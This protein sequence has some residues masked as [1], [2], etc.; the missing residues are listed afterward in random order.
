MTSWTP[1]A[2][3]YKTKVWVTGERRQQSKHKSQK[4]LVVFFRLVFSIPSLF[5]KSQVPYS[6]VISP[7]SYYQP[8]GYA[9]MKGCCQYS[10]LPLASLCSLFSL[11]RCLF[12]KIMVPL[13]DY[14]ISL[15]RF[16]SVSLGM[17]VLYTFNA[18]L[19]VRSWDRT[20]DGCNLGQRNDILPYSMM[21]LCVTEYYGNGTTNFAT[22]WELA[23]PAFLTKNHNLLV[24]FIQATLQ[25]CCDLLVYILFQTFRSRQSMW[26]YMWVKK[27]KLISPN[28]SDMLLN[29]IIVMPCGLIGQV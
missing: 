21:W 19:L 28:L 4:L 24:M 5:D 14:E 12:L 26:S 10:I 15:A 9:N 20:L 29:V 22:K 25:L 6:E 17:L 3:P 8:V 18:F 13:T 27:I 2:W 7:I 1:F 23:I 11:F 16:V